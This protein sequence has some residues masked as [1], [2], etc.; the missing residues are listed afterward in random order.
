[1]TE[2]K[3]NCIIYQ[4]PSKSELG[5]V[6]PYLFVESLAEEISKVFYQIKVRKKFA[7]RKQKTHQVYCQLPKEYEI[8]Q[9]RLI[10]IQIEVI[11][12]SLLAEIKEK[13]RFAGLAS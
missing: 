9:L 12:S 8:Q 13:M 7:S 10:K 5:V 4:V 11:A 2:I 3:Y 6:N 1:M